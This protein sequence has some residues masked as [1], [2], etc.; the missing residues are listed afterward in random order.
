MKKIGTIAVM[1][2]MIVSSSLAGTNNTPPSN[3][4]ELYAALKD[5]N[6]AYT[7]KA[8]VYTDKNNKIWGID[9]SNCGIS[10]LEPLRGMALEAIACS[11]NDIKDLSP[12]AGMKLKQFSCTQTPIED[13]TPLAGMPLWKIE[14]AKT[15]VV[16]LTPLK[17]MPLQMI[18]FNPR[19]ITKGIELLRDMKSLSIIFTEPDEEVGKGTHVRVG[20][21]SEK[22]WEQYDRGDF[23]K[24]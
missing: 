22:F 8:K 12:L 7:G 17:G 16:D 3:E 2:L 23:R 5:A 13:L 20:L 19:V 24:Q 4:N 6:P 14:I 21:G 9:V 15:K 10:N 18:E 11:Q 1:L